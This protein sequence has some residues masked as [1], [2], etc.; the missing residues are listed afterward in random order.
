MKTDSR[1]LCLVD[2]IYTQKVNKIDKRSDIDLFGINFV[3]LTQNVIIS[4][5]FTEWDQKTE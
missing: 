2:A 5:L 4:E 1:K 3:L